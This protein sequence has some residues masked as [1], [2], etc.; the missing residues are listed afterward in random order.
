[1]AT[2]LANA[3]GGKAATEETTS[4]AGGADV[5][6]KTDGGPGPRPADCPSAQPSSG[7]A[8]SKNGLLCEYGD[9]YNPL[10]NTI[11]VCS[12]GKWASPIYYGGGSKCP[13]GGPPSLPPN[14]IDCPGSRDVVS[15]GSSCTTKRSCKYDGSTCSCGVACS[16]YPIR[17]PDC[18]PDAGITTSCC[19]TTKIVWSCFDG[20]AYCKPSRPRVGTAC[21]SGE[22]CAVDEAVE[23][24]QTVLACQKGVWDLVNSSCPVSTAHAKKDITYVDDAQAK[25]LHDELMSVRLARYRY[26]QGDEAPHL[27]FIIDDMPQ[28]SEAV[29]ASRE[30]VDLYGYVSMAV[31]SIQQQQKEIDRLQHDVA[32]LEAENAAMKKRRPR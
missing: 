29:L 26:K 9:D 13:S 14:P 25:E 6:A 30:R 24:G 22:T 7:G 4:D 1:M 21:T 15:E 20:P 2:F 11:V 27:G 18:N 32:R 10:C 12:S 5:E 3:C 16:N 8:C 28:G 31:A 17:M 19:D 23:C